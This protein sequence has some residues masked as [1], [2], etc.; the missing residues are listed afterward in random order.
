MKIYISGPMTG[1]PHL[2]HPEFHRIEKKLRRFYPDAE[3]V[4]PANLGDVKLSWN[5][6][7]RI[8]LAELIKCTHY[9]TL[10]DWYKSRGAT[11]EVGLA[12]NLEMTPIILS[13]EL[14]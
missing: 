5:E 6:N 10:K 9:Y 14:E 11:I 7:M 3:I 8:V 12:L 1:L 2:N 13:G 4:N